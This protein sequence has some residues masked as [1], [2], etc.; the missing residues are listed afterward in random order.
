MLPG[1]FFAQLRAIGEEATVR[2]KP[3]YVVAPV[4]T[5]VSAMAMA[6]QRQE[7][8]YNRLYRH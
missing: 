2:Q 6:F 5:G 1:F 4:A 3:E 8:L 7:A